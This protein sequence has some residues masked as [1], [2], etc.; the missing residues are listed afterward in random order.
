MGSPKAF[1]MMGAHPARP[2]SWGMHEKQQERGFVAGAFY[3]SGNF[4]DLVIWSV[5]CIVGGI[6]FITASIPMTSA[7]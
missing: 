6:F 4:L 2:E 5:L 3:F 7:K 1:S